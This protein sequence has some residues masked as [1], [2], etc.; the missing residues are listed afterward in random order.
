MYEGVEPIENYINCGVGG[1]LLGSLVFV[2]HAGDGGLEQVVVSIDELSVG[3]G[4]QP[5]DSLEVCGED[6]EVF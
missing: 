3:S 5:I 6:L 4:A 2:Y 1:G